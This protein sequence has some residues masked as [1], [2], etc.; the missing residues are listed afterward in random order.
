[1]GAEPAGAPRS[2]WARAWSSSPSSSVHPL[3]SSGRQPCNHGED[4]HDHDEK[5][6]PRP[7]LAV[8]VLVGGDRV[9]VD[10]YGEGR[11]GLVEASREKPVSKGREEERRRLAGDAGECNQD[12][13]QDSGK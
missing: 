5:K 4:E 11:D 3:E 2:S 10:L 13:G 6:R 8:P 12:T 9:S 1:E 7:R